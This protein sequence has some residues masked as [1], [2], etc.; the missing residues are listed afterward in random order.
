[1]ANQL[2][3]STTIDSNPISHHGY[4]ATF[5][6]KLDN[7]Q[8]IVKIFD[9]AKMEQLGL[10]DT[11]EFNQAILSDLTEYVYPRY[12]LQ[13]EQKRVNKSLYLIEPYYMHRL[14]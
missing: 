12:F 4:F 6:G 14:D 13:V 1:M 3:K 5:I 7:R 2:S 9:L 8:K 10:I 11:I